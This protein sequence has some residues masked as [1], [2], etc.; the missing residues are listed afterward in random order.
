[1]TLI[2]I[3][4]LIVGCLGLV[5]LSMGFLWLIVASYYNIKKLRQMKGY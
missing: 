3:G 1:M 4:T 5:A 2:T